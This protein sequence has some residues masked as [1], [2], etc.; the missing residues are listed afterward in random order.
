MEHQ[1]FQDN[2]HILLDET[3]IKINRQVSNETGFIR[4]FH[5]VMRPD[6]R[7]HIFQSKRI[8]CLKKGVWIGRSQQITTLCRHI[9]Q[10][11]Q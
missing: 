9:R 6:V 3:R 2:D 8:F 11:A 1:Q 7:Q 4:D 5:L 10:V